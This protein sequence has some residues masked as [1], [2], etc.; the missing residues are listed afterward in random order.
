M[1]IRKMIKRGLMPHPNAVEAEP[2]VEPVEE[3]SIV[4]KVKKAA[5]KV[6]KKTS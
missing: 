6:I 5:K 1:N 3:V 4:D 2:V